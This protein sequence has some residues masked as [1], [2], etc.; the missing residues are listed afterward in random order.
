M[1]RLMFSMYENG[2]KTESQFA[3]LSISPNESL[4]FRPYFLLVSSIV[5]CGATGF[6]RGLIE[7]GVEFSDIKISANVTRNPDM[8]NRVENIEM[9]F[10]IVGGNDAQRSEVQDGLSEMFEKSAMINSVRE[11]IDITAKFVFA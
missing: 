1:V 6:R 10:T 9:E 3:E 2:F 7:R 8:A 5:G 4:G 11:C